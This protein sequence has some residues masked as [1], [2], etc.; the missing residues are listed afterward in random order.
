[1]LPTQEAALRWLQLHPEI[2]VFNADKNLGPC[3]MER[4]EYLRYAWKDHLSDANTYQRLSQEEADTLIRSVR[5]QIATF[6]E[7]FTKV[8]WSDK[9]YIRRTTESVS[10]D[11]ATSFMYLLAKI[12]KEPLKTRAIISYSGLICYGLAV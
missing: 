6:C 10:N 12:H 9:E 4:E 2:V 11:K 1:L 5:S 8:T 7:I 3:I